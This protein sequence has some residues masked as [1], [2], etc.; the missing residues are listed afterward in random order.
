MEDKLKDHKKVVVAIK[1]IVA[2]I[3]TIILMIL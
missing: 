3:K 1:A 2:K